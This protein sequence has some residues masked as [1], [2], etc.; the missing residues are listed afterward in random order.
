MQYLKYDQFTGRETM[1]HLNRL[2]INLRMIEYFGML[3]LGALC[4]E[5]D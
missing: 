4:L 3:G 1:K 5:D 2:R